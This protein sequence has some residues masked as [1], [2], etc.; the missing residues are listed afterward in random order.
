MSVWCC[1][2]LQVRAART[3]HEAE[4]QLFGHAPVSRDGL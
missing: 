2:D 3:S 1:A 4:E